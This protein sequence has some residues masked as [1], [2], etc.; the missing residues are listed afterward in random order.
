MFFESN[1]IISISVGYPHAH[2]S[3]I[4]PG[5]KTRNTLINI[6]QIPCDPSL[7]LD[8]TLWE[9]FIDQVHVVRLQLLHTRHVV[10]LAVQIIWI[11]GLH[12]LKHVPVLL[13]HEVLVS[14]LTVPWVEGVIP[15]HGQCFGGKTGLVLDDMVKVLVMAPA[16]HHIVEAATGG[17]DPMLGAVH[18]V[19]D[20]RVCC[21]GLG[22]DDALIKGTAHG[23]G[24]ADYIPLALGA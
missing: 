10:T 19:M 6:I 21:K 11:E 4:K 24:V 18:G 2:L 22:E 23:E 9:V 20:V 13:A 8:N 15:D 16:E 5:P 17:V 3:D 7:P 1:A 12:R 14:A